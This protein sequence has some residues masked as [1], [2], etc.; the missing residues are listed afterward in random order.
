MGALR[1]VPWDSRETFSRYGRRDAGQP[2]LT[3]GPPAWCPADVGLLGCRRDEG[4]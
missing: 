1:E 2:G 3:N 4:G